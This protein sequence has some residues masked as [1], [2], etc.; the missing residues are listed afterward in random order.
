MIDREQARF[1]ARNGF[2]QLRGLVPAAACA[3]LVEET[4][5]HLPAHWRR[6]DPRTWRG[7][8]GDS[9]HVAT[10]DFR[11]GLM[12]F[13]SGCSGGAIEERRKLFADP[14]VTANYQDPSPMHSVAHALIGRRLHPI[15]LR[16]LYAIAPV[17]H[18]DSAKAVPS[19]HV[20]AHPA[21]IVALTYLQDVAPGGGGLLVWPGSHRLLHSAFESKLDHVAAPGLE[22]G[23][24]ELRRWMPI[25]LPG[26]RGDIV[27]IHHRL[28][29]SP[30][31][32]RRDR[33]RFG[34]L[35]DYTSVDHLELCRQRPAGLWDDW[36]G[37]VHLAGAD[38][39]D[40]GPDFLRRPARAATSTTRISRP[41]AGLL[42]LFREVAA[43]QRT[44][45]KAEASLLG[46]SRRPG[47]T[48]LTVADCP[49]L[50][51]SNE[52]LDPRGSELAR[53]S[54]WWPT[55]R[56]LQVLLNGTPL[57]SATRGGFTARLDV[58]EGA[59]VLQLLDVRSRL[60][61]RVLEVRAPFSA[62][63]V[64]VRSEVDPAACA[65]IR[66]EIPRAHAS[67]V[68]ATLQQ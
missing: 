4:W 25:E 60:W 5:R 7:P 22:A 18:P 63:R 44:R 53:R 50:F 45:N 8:V 46:R 6:D 40:G 32:N 15:R 62:S 35:C 57:A 68:A 11:G 48:W 17:E 42:T 1:F 16:G 33:I 30:S 2:L 36:P 24:A 39:L 14:V 19:P 9:C 31:I 34:F 10:L 47:E 49:E 64:I 23:I 54:P 51:D 29:H 55:R 21:Q 65:I 52:R 13:A 43:S 26:A 59:N 67:A 58:R 66:F 41:I 38:G 61:L 28:L 27:L 12:K 37:L 56:P 3:H 20:E